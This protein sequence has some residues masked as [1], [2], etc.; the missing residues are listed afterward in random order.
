M[1]PSVFG[2]FYLI[3]CFWDL[4]ILLNVDVV[5]SFSLLQNILVYK[6]IT[7]IYSSFDRYLQLFP[8]WGPLRIM[9]LPTFFV[10]AL[11]A[12]VHIFWL[13]IFLGIIFVFK[14]LLIY[15]PTSSV[16]EFSLFHVVTSICLLALALYFIVI[17]ICIF[18]MSNEVDSFSMFVG[19]LGNLFVK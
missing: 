19:H 18:L 16:W 3:L 4:F 13:G 1:R 15:T 9:L 14:F 6:F 12:Q 2:F 5:C 11:G 7:F 10:M 8:V 17:L